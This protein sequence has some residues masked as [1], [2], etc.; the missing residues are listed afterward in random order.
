MIATK[1][2]RSESAPIRN[3]EDL[4][5]V[6][7]LVRQWTQPPLAF[8][9]VEQTKLITAASELARNTLIYGKGGVFTIEDVTDTAAR[10]G[11]RLSF[12]D[13]GPGIPDITKALQDGF[14]TGGGMGLGLGGAK[15]LVSEFSIDSAPGKGTL[16][17]ITQWTRKLQ[18]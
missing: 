18:K 3:Q 11:L 1:T 6:R 15:R 13:E 7:A 14:T 2:T 10:R 9:T 5:R 16:V 12:R 8:S 4:Q 17:C